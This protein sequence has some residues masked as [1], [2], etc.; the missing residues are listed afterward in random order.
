MDQS[1]LRDQVESMGFQKEDLKKDDGP[2]L[3]YR[4]MHRFLDR[5]LDVLL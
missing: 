2:T 4:Y 1:R 5:A 3:A